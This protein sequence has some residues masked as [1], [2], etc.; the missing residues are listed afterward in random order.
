MFGGQTVPQ[1]QQQNNPEPTLLRHRPMKL[2]QAEV[3]RGGGAHSRMHRKAVTVELTTATKTGA[4]SRQRC[5]N[6]LDIHRATISHAVEV[7]QWEFL[8]LDFKKR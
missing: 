2:L 1:G 5:Y 8:H 4:E 7:L 6:I 3:T